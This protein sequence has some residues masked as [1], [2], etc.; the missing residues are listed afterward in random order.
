MPKLPSLFHCILLSAVAMIASCE[1][2]TS[3]PYGKDINRLRKLIDLPIAPLEAWYGTLPRGVSSW[4]P[5]PTDWVF[6]AVM[7]FDPL[8]L[9]QLLDTTSLDERTPATISRS[10][11]AP[12]FPHEVASAFTP[13]DEK[14]YKV[15]GREFTATP[16][17][18]K[19]GTLS[20]HGSVGTFIVLDGSPFVILQRD[21]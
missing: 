4:V 21:F 18:A 8:A 11:V 2:K 9:K 12:W 16:F 15:K 14:Q 3:P 5:G 6:V 10:D 1:R 17:A 7:R 19:P 20:D 13:F